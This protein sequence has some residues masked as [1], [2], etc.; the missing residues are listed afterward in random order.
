MNW[1]LST[2]AKEIGTMYLVFSVFAGMIGT[3]FSV[4]IRLELAAPGVQIL[5]GDHQLYN[6]IVTAHAFVMIFFMVNALVTQ[7]N[8]L[9]FTTGKSNFSKSFNSNFNQKNFIDPKKAPHKYTKHVIED[10][11][12]NRKSIA[13]IAKKAVGVYIFSSDNGACYIGSSISLYARV[14]SYFMPSI[15]KK[16]DRRVLRYFHK[17]GF[18]GVTL[19]VLIMEPNSTSEMAVELEQYC[20]DTLTPDLNVD[21]V[22]SSTGYHEPISQYWREYFRKIR[23]TR[24]FIYDTVTAK[25]VFISDSVQFIAD[26]VGIHR[27]TVVRYTE[28]GELYLNRFIISYE[29]IT[30]METGTE[31]DLP[32][33]KE[34]L[35]NVRLEHDLAT[36][37]PFS[38]PVLAE[39][40]IH[41]HLTKVYT[42]IHSL[43]KSIKGDRVT[44][45]KYLSG[46]KIG[47]LYRKQWKLTYVDKKDNQK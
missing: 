12:N 20:M 17:Y 30:E 44:I 37:Q 15:L 25:L 10:P 29:P 21:L 13:L 19:T 47:N 40:V 42:S 3:A 33:F 4:L 5:Q 23:G 2:N 45:R 11:Y 14:N 31:L 18:Q 28:S 35:K 32:I 9:K 27:S 39:N 8:L 43:V 16:G 6:V 24:V 1:I 22:A 26:H 36:I 7:I 46:E 34:L 41:P 38:K